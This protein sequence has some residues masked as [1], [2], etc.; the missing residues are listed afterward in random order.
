MTL[1]PTLNL[2]FNP[3]LTVSVFGHLFFLSVFMFLPQTKVILEKIEPVFMVDLI[4]LPGGLMD[5]IESPVAPEPT[6]VE[7][8]EPAPK[9]VATKP[10]QMASPKAEFSPPPEAVAPPPKASSSQSILQELDQ[11]ARLETAKSRPSV[12]D[13]TQAL[14]EETLRELDALKKT[15][16]QSTDPQKPAL[17]EIDNSLEGFENLRMKRQHTPAPVAPQQDLRKELTPEEKQFQEYSQRKVELAAHKKNPAE[18]T[19]SLMKELAALEKIATPSAIPKIKT[20]S[21]SM[22]PMRAPEIAA[23]LQKKLAALQKKK[24]TFNIQTQILPSAGSATA[25]S[26]EIR[27][28]K[29][30]QGG[31]PAKASKVTTRQELAKTLPGITGTGKSGASAIAIYVGLIH[32]RILENWKDPLGGEGQAQVSFIVFREGNIDRVKLIKSSGSTKLDTLAL[33]AVKKSEPFPP[34]PKGLKRPNLPITVNFDYV[35]E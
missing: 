10:K 14:L 19:S 34:F 4:E 29:T 3:M 24:F 26:S 15:P 35:A 1:S 28:V 2:D 22:N 18:T 11:V 25:Y 8:T 27:K 33:L 31:Q 6:R 5:A 17:L 13:P 7:R 16:L 30:M 32:I 12:A 23:A 20:P 21:V 9:P